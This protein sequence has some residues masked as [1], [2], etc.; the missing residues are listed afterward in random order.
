ME[1]VR[2]KFRGLTPN[3]STVSG[4]CPKCDEGIKDWHQESCSKCGVLFDWSR[5]DKGYIT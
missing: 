1:K 3:S 5:A 2:P 4:Y